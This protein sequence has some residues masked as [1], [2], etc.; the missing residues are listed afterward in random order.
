MQIHLPT[1][2]YKLA[3]AS[4]LIV[5]QASWMDSQFLEVLHTCPAV[6]W[7]RSAKNEWSMV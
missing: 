3:A 5:L 2:S 6:Q 7:M 4:Y 1:A